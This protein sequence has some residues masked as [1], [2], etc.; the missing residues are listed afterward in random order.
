M[1]CGGVSFRTL[2][3]PK[4]AHAY[5]PPQWIEIPAA[6]SGWFMRKLVARATIL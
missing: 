6:P 4:W 1:N 2:A 5:C 3:A